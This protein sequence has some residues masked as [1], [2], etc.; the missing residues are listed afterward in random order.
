MKTN[1]RNKNKKPKNEREYTSTIEAQVIELFKN[2]N[3]K[4][5]TIKEI[6]NKLDICYNSIIKTLSRSKEI[7][8]IDRGIY[9]LIEIS[10]NK[11]DKNIVLN[12]KKRLE[13][14][15]NSQIKIL[16][17]NN[18]L[19][20]LKSDKLKKGK[21]GTSS[22]RH[23]NTYSNELGLGSYQNLAIYSDKEVNR[24]DTVIKNEGITKKACAVFL[25]NPEKAFFPREIIKIIELN[26]YL[27]ER[28]KHNKDSIRTSI[29]R[30][31]E[32]RVIQQ[33]PD[34]RYKLY[35]REFAINYLEQNDIMRSTPRS[36]IMMKHHKIYYQYPVPIPD[37]KYNLVM[38]SST[39]PK[40]ND[41]AQQRSLKTKN[42]TAVIYPKNKTAMFY[43]HSNN[44]MEDVRKYFGKETLNNLLCQNPKIGIAIEK[45]GW[46]NNKISGGDLKVSLD[47]SQFKDGEICLH[48]NLNNVNS[49]VKNL[50]GSRIELTTFQADI[51]ESLEKLFFQNSEKF[52]IM[53]ANQNKTNLLLF[54]FLE[55][56][57]TLSDLIIKIDNKIDNN[58][59]NFRDHF[60]K[61]FTDI[62][63]KEFANIFGENINKLTIELKKSIENVFEKIFIKLPEPLPIDDNNFMFE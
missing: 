4:R 47:R 58:F 34:K 22:L 52:E 7:R 17:K 19:K 62:F 12:N 31:K 46:L 23:S 36:P 43:V 39:H 29:R 1:P 30:L 55:N 25:N 51:K 21:K 28:K 6:S 56:D 5:L 15:T 13:K 9:Q 2:N 63:L 44:W 16:D 42:I 14:V 24:P 35:I 45:N 41:R 59:S 27:D 61:Q 50:I 32:R 38:T 37:R 60:S 8:K 53:I 49:A 54:H 20:D 57:K 26:S 18:D 48:G 33:L 10:D 3:N 11:S 40:E